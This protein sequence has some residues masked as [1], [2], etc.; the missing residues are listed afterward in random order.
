[1]NYI[2]WN[3]KSTFK[4]F[5]ASI[6]WIEIWIQICGDIEILYIRVRDV[7]F[8]F[9]FF[10]DYAEISKL[11]DQPVWNLVKNYSFTYWVCGNSFQNKKVKI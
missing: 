3:P 6:L 11:I 4:E 10:N 5:N 2:S 8:I 7:I 1:M 9:S